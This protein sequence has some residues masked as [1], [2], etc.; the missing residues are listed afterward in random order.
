MKINIVCSILILFSEFVLESGGVGCCLKRNIVKCEINLPDKT[1]N[2][3]LGWVL[4]Y[5][6]YLEKL[7]LLEK[8]FKL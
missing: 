3:P 1:H 5:L 8:G 7:V 6:K 4:Y 2:T